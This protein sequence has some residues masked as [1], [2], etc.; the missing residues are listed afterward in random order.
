MPM[1]IASTGRRFELVWRSKLNFSP[2]ALEIFPRLSHITPTALVSFC[3]QCSR[4]WERDACEIKGQQATQI[5]QW[6]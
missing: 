6:R 5:N 2:R 3:F 4:S 1:S